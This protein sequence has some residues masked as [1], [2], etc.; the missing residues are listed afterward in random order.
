VDFN[1]SL[2]SFEP[3]VAGVANLIRLSRESPHVVPITFVSS[4][5]VA[6]NWKGAQGSQIPEEIIFD[7]SAAS[8]GYGQS[9]LVAEHLLLRAQ[10]HGVPSTILRV[11]QIAG[12]VGFADKGMW[13]KKEWLPTVSIPMFGEAVCAAWCPNKLTDRGGLGIYEHTS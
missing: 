7:F 9:K 6:G 3:H 11:G 4:V 1:L 8:M 10:K 12:P 5:G 13:N 2:S